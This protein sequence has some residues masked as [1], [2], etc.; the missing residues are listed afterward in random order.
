[1]SAKRNRLHTSML[2]PLLRKKKRVR[3]RTRTVER[4]NPVVRSSR[5][6]LPDHSADR[7]SPSHGSRAQLLLLSLPDPCTVQ[8]CPGQ[9]T[10]TPS[11]V[12]VWRPW[13]ALVCCLG[14]LL[15]KPILPDQLALPSVLRSGYH[16]AA[17]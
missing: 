8:Q 13:G 3:G 14:V 16:T 12:A 5:A 1:M 15:A 7:P 6:F 11:D 2:R 4:A 9:S 17:P 10:N